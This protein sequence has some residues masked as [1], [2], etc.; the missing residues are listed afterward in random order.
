MLAA[1]LG[2]KAS[3][4]AGRLA[5]K[6]FNTKVTR[7]NG[8]QFLLPFGLAMTNVRSVKLFHF[9]PNETFYYADYLYSPTNRRWEC[10]L[11]QNGFDGRDN[12]L[13]ERIVGVVPI[14][15]AGGAMEEIA[16]YNFDFLDYGQKQL[17]TFL[18]AGKPVTPPVVA[19]GGPA[20]DCLWK[21]TRTRSKPSW[22]GGDDNPL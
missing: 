3:P 18:A 9:P 19:Y 15:A 8:L 21:S 13:V 2:D 6:T 7:A 20:R 22:A 11:A 12:T 16:P 17:P 14:A 1:E 10:L 5:L 4:A